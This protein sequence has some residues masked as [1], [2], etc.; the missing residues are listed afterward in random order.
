[1]YSK[2]WLFFNAYG[3]KAEVDFNVTSWFHFCNRMSL[4]ETHKTFLQDE[5]HS[6]LHHWLMMQLGKEGM[7]HQISEASGV[8]KKRQAGDIDGSLNMFA[9]RRKSK[10]QVKPQ[11]PLFNVITGHLGAPQA[12]MRNPNHVYDL[13]SP[14]LWSLVNEKHLWK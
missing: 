4:Q 10:G 13:F 8:W 1:M 2:F 11:E 12:G 5:Q 9:D 7:S 14:S 3:Y 6:H